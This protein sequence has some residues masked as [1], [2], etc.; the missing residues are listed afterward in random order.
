[1]RLSKLQ[2]IILLL[3]IR[4]SCRDITHCIQWFKVDVTPAAVKA[5]YY[6]FPLSPKGR[7]I[8]FDKNEVGH[9]RYNNASVAIAHAFGHLARKGLA[10]WLKGWGL[11][12]TEK[13][14]EV[15]EQI[16]ND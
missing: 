9:S 15:A 11:R 8:F 10:E 1:M 6:N 14:Q 5:A 13:G 3:A 4:N 16:R 7:K 12:L 2:R